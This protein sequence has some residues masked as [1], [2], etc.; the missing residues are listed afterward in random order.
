MIWGHRCTVNW[1]KMAQKKRTFFSNDV[2]LMLP[3][4]LWCW[5]MPLSGL[6]NLV[7]ATFSPIKKGEV[8]HTLLLGLYLRTPL[9][10]QFFFRKGVT[11]LIVHL[12]RKFEFEQCTRKTPVRRDN[13]IIFST[14]FSSNS[15]LHLLVITPEQPW[16]S[17][18]YYLKD[19]LNT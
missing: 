10:W 16:L 18:Y 15:Q 6:T 14:S 13:I 4:L 8:S 2:I 7:W 5:T 11:V 17:N 9:I 19:I 3:I 12:K 1:K